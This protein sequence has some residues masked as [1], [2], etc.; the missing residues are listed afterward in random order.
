MAH[1]I[2]EG[3]RL[4][5]TMKPLFMALKIFGILNIDSINCK[6]KRGS[7]PWIVYFVLVKLVLWYESIRLFMT[8]VIERPEASLIA[9]KTLL[10]GWLIATNL[11]TIILGFKAKNFCKL[12]NAWGAGYADEEENYT[13]RKQVTFLMVLVFGS[14]VIPVVESSVSAFSTKSSTRMSVVLGS[15]PFPANTTPPLPYAIFQAGTFMYLGFI[16]IITHGLFVIICYAVQKE[17]QRF[18]EQFSKS[19][20][21]GSVT[22]KIEEMRQ[23]YEKRLDMVEHTNSI[24]STILLITIA[25]ELGSA[26]FSI[27]LFIRGYDIDI[28]IFI[29]AFDYFL[30]TGTFIAGIYVNERVTHIILHIYIY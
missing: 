18:T 5:A 17:L 21:D 27:F 22:E 25:N 13:Y 14:S 3:N 23:T 6:G 26:C 4:F 11:A 12:F 20:D 24:Y 2:K 19:L 16:S 9:T 10:L 30:L 28:A 15:V 1:T 8:L 29:I 7:A